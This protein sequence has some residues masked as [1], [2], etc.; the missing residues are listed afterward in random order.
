MRVGICATITVALLA[1]PHMVAAMPGASPSVPGE[2]VA[3][4]RILT[5]DQKL[6]HGVGVVTAVD[7]ESGVVTIDHKAIPGLMDAM[8]MDY[9][10]SPKSLIAGLKKGDHV[11]FDVDGNSYAVRAIKR[12]D[13]P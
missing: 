7:A 13:A 1:A 8:E 12:V 6:F 3:P 11:E 9:T 5:A 2:K 4:L 10:A